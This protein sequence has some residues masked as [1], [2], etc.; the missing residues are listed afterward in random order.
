MRDKGHCK[1]WH[2]DGA[3]VEYAEYFDYTTSYPEDARDAE[4]EAVNVP[5]LSSNDKWELVLPSG[6]VIGHRSLARYY[7]QNLKPTEGT[8]VAYGAA[9]GVTS[10]NSRSMKNSLLKQYRSLGWTGCTT[11]KAQA[12][13]RAKDIRF[14]K[15]FEAKN[16]LRLGVKAN[17]LQRY[18][19][20]QDINL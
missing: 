8:L 11:N 15:K 6:A 16:Q 13:Q 5:V 17:K 2:D 18:F 3:M 9:D 12:T 19:K 7:R 14:W 20:R 4:E 10:A 1:V